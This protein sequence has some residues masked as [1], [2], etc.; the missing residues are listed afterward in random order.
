[1]AI[2]ETQ[3]VC[4]ALVKQGFTQVHVSDDECLFA[5][6]PEKRPLPTRG[7]K[8][9]QRNRRWVPGCTITESVREDDADDQGRSYRRFTATIRGWEGFRLWQG[10]LDRPC[11]EIAKEVISMVTAIRD[12]IDAGDESD[13]YAPK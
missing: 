6:P 9:L 12:R 10:Y 2:S 11:D 13:F 7:W 5:P 3:R 8:V 4:I 1:M